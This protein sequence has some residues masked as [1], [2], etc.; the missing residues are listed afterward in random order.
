MVYVAFYLVIALVGSIVSFS[1]LTDL[2]MEFEAEE[3]ISGLYLFN[4]EDAQLHR[5]R[6]IEIAV[7]KDIDGFPVFCT[8]F[9]QR[10]SSPDDALDP[11]TLHERYMFEDVTGYPGNTVVYALETPSATTSFD[12][13]AIGLGNDVQKPSIELSAATLA[14]YDELARER[15]NRTITEPLATYVASA[16]DSDITV[17]PVAYNVYVSTSAQQRFAILALGFMSLTITEPLATYVASAYDSDI[18]V[19]PVAYNVYVS[20][21]AQQRFAILALGFMSLLVFPLWF[22]VCIWMAARRFFAQ[23]IQPALATLDAAAEKITEQDLDFTVAYPRDDEMG[24]LAQSFETMRASLAQTQRTLW[25]TAEEHR[26][27]NA[28]FAHDL[29]T[30]LTVLHGKLELL[31]A[32]AATGSIAPDRLARD[33]RTLATQVERLEAYVAAMSSVRRLEDR[34]VARAS[35]DPASL[36]GELREIGEQLCASHGVSFSLTTHSQGTAPALDRSLV[37][38]VAENLLG[39]AVRFATTDV[40]ADVDLSPAGLVLTVSDDGPGFS[41]EA[42]QQGCEPFYSEHKNEGHFGLGLN[43]S[44]LLCEKHGGSLVLSNRP[45]GG[46]QIVATFR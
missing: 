11:S 34:P 28:A 5:A 35:V 31:E 16:Y 12:T 29:R 30:P 14:A 33:C 22:M 32:R 41:P 39:N 37:V 10:S 45:E 1:L 44:H 42:L 27:L 19:S 15:F 18:T 26:R 23:R 40:G 36:F 9:V 8:A 4:P 24:H 3:G 46:A 20:T 21:S 7:G 13:F 38:E 2:R 43:I 25:R 17:S 6:I